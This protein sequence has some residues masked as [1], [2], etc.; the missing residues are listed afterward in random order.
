MGIVL[1]RGRH[2]TKQI[3]NIDLIIKNNKIIIPFIDEYTIA[4]DKG[5]YRPITSVKYVFEVTDENNKKSIEV[6]VSG[7]G[8]LGVPVKGDK[9]TLK[10][11]LDIYSANKKIK[12]L[13]CDS[14][15]DIEIKD[16]NEL[17][18]EIESIDEI[19]AKIGYINVN[20]EIRKVIQ[21][22]IERLVATT[23]FIEYKEK[24]TGS[25]N[26][27]CMERIKKS[28]RLLSEMHIIHYDEE[29]SMSTQGGIKCKLKLNILLYENI[30]NFNCLNE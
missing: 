10:A 1:T 5:E 7:H 3:K 13:I 21:E 6:E 8:K 24:I 22:S 20:D 17:V 11:L 30:L 9:K 25:K 23:L 28:C 27:D 19:A 16:N 4:V 26:D 12:N 29:S 14:R 18:I 2:I 15:K